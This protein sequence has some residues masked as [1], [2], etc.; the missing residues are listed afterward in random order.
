MVRADLQV[1]GS[2]GLVQDTSD[3]ELLASAHT[4]P[5]ASAAFPS[6]DFTAEVSATAYWWPFTQPEAGGEITM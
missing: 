3:S 5:A 1:P 2:L 6:A 4:S